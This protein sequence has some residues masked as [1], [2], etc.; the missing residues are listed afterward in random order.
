MARGCD[1]IGGIILAAMRRAVDWVCAAAA[2]AEE[3]KCF[4]IYVARRRRVVWSPEM[5]SANVWCFK[6]THSI[7]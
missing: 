7:L 4:S 3:R 2:A 5:H 6:N 1:F